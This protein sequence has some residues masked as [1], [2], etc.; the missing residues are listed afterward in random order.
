MNCPLCNGQGWIFV[1]GLNQAT[2]SLCNGQCRVLDDPTRVEQCPSCSG[3]KFTSRAIDRRIVQAV[4]GVCS[5]WGR[6][7]PLLPQAALV[8]GPTVVYV[9]AGKPYTA[10]RQLE[11][12]FLTITGEI[13]ICDPYYGRKTL[14]RLDSLKHCKPIKFLT[15]KPDAQETQTVSTALQLWKAEHGTIEFRRD[16]GRDIHDR[17]LLSDSELILL[18]HGLKDVGNKESFIIRL[19]RDVAGD[20]MDTVRDAFDA[21]WQTATSI[22]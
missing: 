8:E 2:C 13:R 11:E 18:G 16:A 17:F 7:R 6:V 20:L 4:C 1:N 10:Q 3:T 21:K 19:G 5:G 14:V 15:Q 9:E 22:V 12:L